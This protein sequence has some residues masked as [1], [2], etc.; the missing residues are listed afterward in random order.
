MYYNSIKKDRIVENVNNCKSTYNLQQ[1]HK[2][3]T[4]N[5]RCELCKVP[6]EHT[7]KTGKNRKSGTWKYSYAINETLYTILLEINRHND[8][9]FI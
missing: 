2:T 4:L 3:N 7:L 6:M 8:N 1:W 5:M 9:H